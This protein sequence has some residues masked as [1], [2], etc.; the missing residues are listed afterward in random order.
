MAAI[1][2]NVA[3]SYKIWHLESLFWHQCIGKWIAI[4]NLSNISRLALIWP[5]QLPFNKMAAVKS[6]CLYI[7]KTRYLEG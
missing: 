7:F 6:N 3:I 1:F 5:S 2:T 4:F